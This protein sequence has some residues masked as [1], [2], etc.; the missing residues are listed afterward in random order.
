MLEK[1]KQEVCSGN[2]ELPRN[3]LVILTWGNLSAIDSGKKIV[4]IKPSGVSFEEMVP[5]DIVL[6]DLSGKVIEGEKRPS[7]DTPTHLEIY[8]K[9][10]E[11]KSIVHTHSV[12]ATA[13]AQAEKEI[14]CLG[15]THA[16]CFYGN[17]PVTRKLTEGETLADYEKNTGKVIVECFIKNKIQPLDVPAC[18][19]ACHGPFVFGDSVG[20]AV[21][22]AVT[23]EQVARINVETKK[24]NGNVRQIDSFLLEKHFKRKHGKN[25]YYGQPKE[26]D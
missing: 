7:S 24:I 10:P 4:A 8:R 20:N 5:E 22:N 16:D 6:L 9:F 18:L 21:K 15:T 2:K 25:A 13:F 19:V 12:F 23:L 17:V 14:E 11:I 1:L 26:K 3:G